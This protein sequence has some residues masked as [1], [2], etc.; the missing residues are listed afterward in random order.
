MNAELDAIQ[1]YTTAV[2]GANG[3]RLDG[4]TRASIFFRFVSARQN[5]KVEAKGKRRAGSGESER[6]SRL[7][8]WRP[9]VFDQTNLRQANLSQANFDQ[10]ISGQAS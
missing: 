7:P 2:S 10:T 3:H 8:A 6:S 9:P 1:L 4:R 5:A